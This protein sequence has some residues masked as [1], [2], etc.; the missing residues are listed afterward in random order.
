MCVCLYTPTLLERALSTWLRSQEERLLEL[1]GA[2][3]S[4]FRP[5]LQPPCRINSALSHLW[6]CSPGLNSHHDTWLTIDRGTSGRTFLLA[7]PGSDFWRALQCAHH[8]LWDN[9][10]YPQH[11]PAYSSPIFP[12]D[13]GQGC[14]VS[15]GSHRARA[16]HCMHYSLWMLRR[17]KPRCSGCE[18][19]PC[20]AQTASPL[21]LKSRH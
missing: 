1:D 9:G 2:E 3:V 6:P 12:E 4:W 15:V 7:K 19:W 10:F 16:L 11:L 18:H 20:L 14:L 17:Q 21:P 13:L 5:V 8:D